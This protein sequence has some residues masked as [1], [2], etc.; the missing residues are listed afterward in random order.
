MD[1][2]SKLLSTRFVLHGFAPVHHDLG[3]LFPAP[4]L[5]FM[6]REALIVLRA[7][8]RLLMA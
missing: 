8:C 3:R 7:S 6:L 2:W 5:I 4:Y 1:Y